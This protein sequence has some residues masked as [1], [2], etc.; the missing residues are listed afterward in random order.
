MSRVLI[1]G[2]THAPAMRERYPDFLEDIY[3]QWD[4][5]RVV[6]IGDA[7]DFHGISY[8]L[9]HTDLPNIEEELD[10]AVGQ[11][12]ELYDRFPDVD[13]MTGNHSDLP[14]RQAIGVGIPAKL[15]RSLGEILDMPKGWVVHPRFADLDI[16]GVFYRHGDKG[17]SNV[18]NAARA[19]ADAE[20]RS[21][22]CGH[23]HA[24]GGVS[25][26]ANMLHRWFGMQVGCGTETNSP[27]MRY[28]KIYAAKPIVGCGVVLDGEYPIF[29]PMPLEQYS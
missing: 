4:C 15:M 10:I 23:Y 24:Q 12:S 28:S 21:V 1:I 29:E 17:K 25:F 18:L 14:N 26:G 11:L 5:D 8:H 6:H 2:D 13:Y 27:Y 20:H 7:V 3:E 22:V 19:Q 16:D 9:K